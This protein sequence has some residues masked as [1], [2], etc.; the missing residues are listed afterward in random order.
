[1]VFVGV[2]T[3][4]RIGEILALRWRDV[5]FH[6]GE[7]RSSRPVTGSNRRA[8]DQ[9]QRRTLPM[10]EPLTDVLKRL[11]EKSASG[12]GLVSSHSQWHPFS[13]TKLLH[14]H[15]KPV[16]TEARDALAQL[17]HFVSNSR[18]ALTTRGSH[19]QIGSGTVG[20]FEDVH[21]P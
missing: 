2:L 16:R 4:L 17:A 14:K 15:L 20:S 13:D 1:M 6:S 3:G 21:Y 7:I 19:A 9:R 10:P 18:H 11:R 8:K 12:E 5:D